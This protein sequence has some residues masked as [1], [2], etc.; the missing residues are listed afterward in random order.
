MSCRGFGLMS[1]GRSAREERVRSRRRAIAV[2]LVA[3]GV[4]VGVVA[5]DAGGDAAASSPA[6]PLCRAN[7]LRGSIGLQGAVGSLAG[8]ITFGNTA[9]ASCVLRGYPRITLRGADGR[10]IRTT[11]SLG[12]PWWRLVSEK[13][14]PPHGWPLV[15]LQP[16]R[17]ALVR[18]NLQNWC[19]KNGERVAFTVWLPARGGKLHVST[20]IS[21]ACYAPDSPA[22]LNFGPFEPAAAERP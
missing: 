8:G 3:M 9:R 22:N 17:K 11:E 12:P 1:D 10:H 15:L 7:Q 6:H 19:G 14:K 18:V 13:P 20:A 5:V 4:F 16:K 21:L 2:A